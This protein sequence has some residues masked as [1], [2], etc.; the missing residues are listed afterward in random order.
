MPT[1]RNPAVAGQFYSGGRERLLREIEGCFNSPLG[2]GGVPKLNQR[3]KR[4]IKGAV[5]PHA[6]FVYSGPVAAHTY[7]ALA[8][9]GF[10]KTFVIIGPNHTGMGSGV[11]IT[12]ET[13]STPLGDVPVD[14]ELAKDL[15]KDAVDSDVASHR[16]EHSIEVQLPFLQ[17]IKPEISIVPVCMMIQDYG[18]AEKVGR[19][20]GEAI[21]GK[22]AVVLASTDFS[23]Y[24]RKSVAAKYDS[25]AIDCI[26]ERNPKKL[27][28][29]VVKND[30][31]MCGYGPVMAMLVATSVTG[32]SKA[33]L[34]KYATSG[35]VTSMSDVVGY[36]AIVV[37]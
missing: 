26:L 18:M 5:V 24:V 36:A 14:A 31:S 6:G 9:D 20:I 19:L 33:E 4:E 15:T 17:Y 23:H 34:L 25:M 28:D 11:A 1:K 3:G 16:D 7:S 32:S 8:G 30:I 37:K 10:P 2:P 27:Y 21:R 12:T 13:F 29:T 35:D 22:D